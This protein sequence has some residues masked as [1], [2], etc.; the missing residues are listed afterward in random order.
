MG[1]SVEQE[2]STTK[3]LCQKVSAKGHTC[4]QVRL[5]SVSKYLKTSWRGPANFGIAWT[6]NMAE[7]SFGVFVRSLT[8]DVQ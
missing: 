3:A 6:S 1:N 2:P 4:A 7:V 8:A 5:W